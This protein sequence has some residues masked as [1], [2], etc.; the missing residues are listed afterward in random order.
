MPPASTHM[1]LLYDFK[2]LDMLRRYDS[3][4]NQMLDIAPT[5]MMVKTKQLSKYAKMTKSPS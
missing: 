5:K 4:V 1:M 2:H 3:K